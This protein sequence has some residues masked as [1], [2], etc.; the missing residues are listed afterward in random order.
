VLWNALVRGPFA[1]IVLVGQVHAVTTVVPGIRKLIFECVVNLGHIQA[2]FVGVEVTTDQI[3]TAPILL[4]L[5]A[6]YPIDGQSVGLCVAS[7]FGLKGR[8]V[9]HKAQMIDSVVAHSVHQAQSR[10]ADGSRVSIVAT[11][12]GR[13]DAIVND[14]FLAWL[15]RRGCGCLV[16]YLHT[17]SPPKVGIFGVIEGSWKPSNTAM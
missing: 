16:L 4:G 8:V 9:N 11:V 7:R 15:I 13:R 14:E 12:G 5:V 17:P 2:R 6:D 1:S 10:L 3:W